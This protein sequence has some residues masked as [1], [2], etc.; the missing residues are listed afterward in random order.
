METDPS[1]AQVEDPNDQDLQEGTDLGDDGGDDDL[2]GDDDGES[3]GESE[4]PTGP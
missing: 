4:A 1:D 2:G 3:A